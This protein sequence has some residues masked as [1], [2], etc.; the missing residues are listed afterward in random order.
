MKIVH[1]VNSNIFTDKLSNAVITLPVIIEIKDVLK[2]DILLIFRFLNEIITQVKYLQ[3]MY[4][5]YS[6]ISYVK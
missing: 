2:A 6:A 1:T 4:T 5:N 3:Q